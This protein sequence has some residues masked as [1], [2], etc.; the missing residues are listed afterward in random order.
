M[1]TE[2]LDVIAQLYCSIFYKQKRKGFDKKEIHLVRRQK[3]P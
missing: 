2:N 1:K 3:L